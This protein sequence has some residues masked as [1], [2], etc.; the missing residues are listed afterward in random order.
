MKEDQHAFIFKRTKCQENYRRK[1]YSIFIIFQL[2]QETNVWDF[3][4]DRLKS[5]TPLSPVEAVYIFKQ[6]CHA[7]NAMETPTAGMSHRDVKPHNILLTT[8]RPLP[9]ELR[10]VATSQTTKDHGNGDDAA[11]LIVPAPAAGAVAGDAAGLT[12]KQQLP[13]AV[14][15]DFGSVAPATVHITSRTEALSAQEDAEVKNYFPF[16]YLQIFLL[17]SQHTLYISLCS[18]ILQLPTVLQSSGMSPHHVL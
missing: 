7:L 5:N 13:H 18:D 17:S 9:L 16:K 11:H 15:M 3:V 1:R 12:Q 4:Q 6:L 2:L 10:I 14:L 8:Q